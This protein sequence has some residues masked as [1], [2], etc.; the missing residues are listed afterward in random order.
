VNW[1]LVQVDS[2]G[3]SLAGKSIVALKEFCKRKSARVSERLQVAYASD[4]LMNMGGWIYARLD[5]RIQSFRDELRA[6]ESDQR[7]ARHDECQGQE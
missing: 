3:M 7:T 4:N 6:V 5:E 2:P 1:Q